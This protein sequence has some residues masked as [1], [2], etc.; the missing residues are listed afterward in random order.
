M[1]LHQAFTVAQGAT[2]LAGL[3]Q[4]NTQL[5]PEVRSDPGPGTPFPQFAVLVSQRPRIMFASQA[6]AAA[7][8][9]TGSTGLSFTS[10]G[11]PL[12]AHLVKIG[13]NGLAATGTVHRRYRATDGLL[14]PRRLNCTGRQ[15]GVLDMEALL[16]SPDGATHPLAIVDNVALPALARDSVHHTLGPISL[17]LAD[18]VIEAKCLRNLSIDF[19]SSADTVHCGSDLYDTHIQQPGIR[20]VITLTGIDAT[21]FGAGGVPP[22]GK[23]LDHANTKICL[24]KYAD[25]DVGFV[26]DDEEEHILIT[27]D[28]IAVV[29]EHTGQGNQPS[30]VTVQIT[31]NWDGTN[32]PITIDVAAEI[33]SG[34]D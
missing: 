22:V 3:T 26:A 32:A 34:G 2:A 9:L 23:R 12:D 11:T 33:D 7:L 6:V 8:T 18:A 31:C 4:L 13:A 20:P 5:N 28:G 16:I 30:E 1:S 25:D 17:G 14:V 21:L 29:T 10:S 19:G 24:R 15:F 27:A